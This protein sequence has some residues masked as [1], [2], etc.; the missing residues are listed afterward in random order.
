MSAE[1]LSLLLLGSIRYMKRLLPREEIASCL[2]TIPAQ[3]VASQWIIDPLNII[4]YVE[5][6]D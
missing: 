3:A 5:Q 4:S 1:A 6:K 2:L